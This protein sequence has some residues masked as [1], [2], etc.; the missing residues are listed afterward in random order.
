MSIDGT[1]NVSMKTPMGTMQGELIL[2]T[3]GATLT[4]SLTGPS[5]PEPLVDGVVDGDDLTWTIKLS[6]PMSMTIHY[7]VKIDGDS[8]NGTAKLGVF[9]PTSIVGTRAVAEVPAG[10]Q[11]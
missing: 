2:V 8:L 11:A 6:K 7:K 1:W 5:G 10:D 3:S 4:G 9:K